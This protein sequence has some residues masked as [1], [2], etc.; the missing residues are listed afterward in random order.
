MRILTVGNRFEGLG[1]YEAM[2]QA[3]VAG[4]RARGHDVRVLAP[5]ELRWYW[6]DHRWPRD[7]RWRGRWIERH[8]HRVFGEAARDADLVSFWS[9]GGLSMSLLSHRPAIAFVHDAWPDYGPRVDARFR[10]PLELPPAYW[11]SGHTRR[12]RPGEVLPSGFDE[13]VYTKGPERPVWQGRLL[14]PGR[15]D[16]RKGHR[17][18][19]EAFG[20]GFAVAG[21]GED[22][23]TAELRAAGVELL[24]HRTPSELAADYAASDAVLFPVT[25]DEPWGLVPLEAMAVGRPVVATGTGGSG[26]YLRHEVNCL[27]V[28]RG[29]AGALRAAVERLAGDPALRARLRE[30]GLATAPRH[31]EAV[32]N[33]AVERAVLEAAA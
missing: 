7:L 4:L 5:P 20:G 32:L 15:I 11:V 19:L 2:W 31:T 6:R 1:G 24:G 13:T 21:T 3:A 27:L 30:G 9:M 25:W 26:E 16:P 29:D 33:E 8:N 22:G 18:A 17:V 23:L 12:S 28:P 14:L 10:P